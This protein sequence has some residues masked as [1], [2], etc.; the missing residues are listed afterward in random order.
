MVV[1]I[2]IYIYIYIYIAFQSK[3]SS[4]QNELKVASAKAN[5][6]DAEQLSNLQKENEELKKTLDSNSV[7][8]SEKNKI[9]PQVS[10]H[11]IPKKSCKLCFARGEMYCS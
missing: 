7:E 3:T 11:V 9:I 8:L 5:K 4:L 10:S 2:Y 6:S 1:C